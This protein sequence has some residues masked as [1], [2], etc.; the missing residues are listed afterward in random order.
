MDRKKRKNRRAGKKFTQFRE[1]K[2][3]KKKWELNMIRNI[4]TKYYGEK[5]VLMENETESYTNQNK[6]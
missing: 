1:K 4:W 6:L 5:P 3:E 2:N